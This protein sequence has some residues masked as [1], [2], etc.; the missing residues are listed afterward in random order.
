[1]ALEAYRRALAV[2]RN[3]LTAQEGVERTEPRAALEAQLNG[4]AARPER[5][6]STE[7]RAAAR[8]TLSRARAVEPAG[9]VLRKQIETVSA[10]VAAAEMPVAVALTSDNQTDVTIYRIGR[11]GLF[12]RKD[13]ELLPGRYTIVGTRS[14]FRDVRRELMVL[15]GQ[16]PPTVAIRCEEPI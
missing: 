1:V 4:F 6:F 2:D 11:I 12:E 16:V 15:P 14:G 10:L 7:V 5:L 13:M 3:L 9:P 8:T